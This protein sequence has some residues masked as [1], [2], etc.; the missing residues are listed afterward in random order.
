[1]GN[2]LELIIVYKVLEVRM[3]TL[4]FWTFA[5]VFIV[6]PLVD[7]VNNINRR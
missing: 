5:S 6:G 1:M 7:A 2:Y 3:M 4:I